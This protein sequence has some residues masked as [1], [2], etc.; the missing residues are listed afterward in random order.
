MQICSYLLD[1]QF[2]DRKS[3]ASYDIY[4]ALKAGMDTS[5]SNQ[6]SMIHDTNRLTSTSPIC[7]SSINTIQ[8]SLMCWTHLYLHI[9]TYVFVFVCAHC[10]SFP[11]APNWLEV[12]FD[13][14]SVSVTW[15]PVSTSH[16]QHSMHALHTA[17]CISLLCY[18]LY[19]KYLNTIIFVLVMFMYVFNNC[20]YSWN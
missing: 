20:R 16:S 11:F 6:Y 9:Y 12:T 15:F 18:R 19:W 13:F 4:L 17:Y 2:M 10:S 7:I 5:K 3:I 14:L 8:S 1:I